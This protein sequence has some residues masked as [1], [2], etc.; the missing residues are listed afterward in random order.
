MVAKRVALLIETSSSWGSLV[1]AGISDYVR[2][3]DRWVLFLDHRGSREKQTLPAE[4]QVDGVIARVT[5]SA[6]AE[7]VLRRRVPC[8]NVSQIRVPGDAIQQVTTNAARI[9]QLGAEALISAGLREFAYYG[10][11]PREFYSD[12][13]LVAFRAGLQKAGFT[14][15]VIDRAAVHSPDPEH[16]LDLPAL[17]GELEKLPLPVGILCWDA[18]AAHHINEACCWAGLRVP[19]Q[20][21]VLAG[22]YDQL[23]TE[24]ST[25]RLTSLDHVPRRVGYLAATELTRLMNGGPVRPPVLAEP[26]GIVPGASVAST[27]VRDKLVEEAIAFIGANSGRNIS[28]PDLLNA[29]HTS[30]RNL[31]RRFREAVGRGPAA[32]IRRV[33]LKDARR[34]LTETDLA[35]KT[36]AIKC[37]FANPEQLQRLLRAETAMTPSQYREAHRRDAA[38]DS[39]PSH[40]RTEP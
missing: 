34:L 7:S 10:P 5:G 19:E 16:N 32:E 24:I 15:T 13:I 30:R 36:I 26:K 33:R 28:I 37:G 3:H 8:V 22:S 18:L 14:L 23:T 11:P 40:L 4:W 20:V 12:E 35:I 31:E 39:F 38:G 9:G 27:G 25:P 6:L 1:I 17:A 29:V 21:S 2:R